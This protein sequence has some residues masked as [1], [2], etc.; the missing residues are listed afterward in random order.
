MTVSTLMKLKKKLKLKIQYILE[1]KL[2]KINV[3]FL[4]IT[5]LFVNPVIGFLEYFFVS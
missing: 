2:L 3:F 4:S 5:L 1:I